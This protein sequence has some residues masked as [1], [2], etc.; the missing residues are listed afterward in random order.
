MSSFIIH[1]GKPL[2]GEVEVGGSK[3]AVLPMMA[4]AILA[5]APVELRGA[6]RVADVGGAGLGA[7]RTR[8][9]RRLERRRA[10]AG[11]DRP[12]ARSVPWRW[13]RRM[14]ASFCVLGPL[15]ARRGKAIVPLP[16]GCNLGDRPVDLHLRGLAALGAELKLEGGCVIARAK[17]L[18]GATVDLSGP[19]GPTVTGT[20]NVL[21]AAALA[22][23]VTRILA[24]AREPEIV[25]LG[26]LLGIM[27]AN[28]AGLGT[29][30]I[31]VRGVDSLGGGVHRVIPDRIETATLLLAA[32]ITGGQA[33]ATGAAP[34]HLQAVLSRL[35]DCGAEIEVAGDRVALR[36]RRPL[37]PVDIVAEPYPGVPTDLQ[38]QWTAFLSLA[39]GRSTI[40]DRVF[41]SRFFH[42]AELNRMGARIVVDKATA[43]VAGVER[44]GG[45]RVVASDLRAGAALVLAGLAAEGTTT[46]HRI[47]HLDRGYEGLDGKLRR[48]GAD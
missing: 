8:H 47:A 39:S 38:A 22:R 3:N 7:E 1:G 36:A 13:V 24:A 6:P 20:A 35:A 29:S 19:R 42:V 14:R 16:G 41:P 37:R 21:C 10:A 11:N 45:A 9:G 12:H 31:E 40:E 43:T 46:V 17:R 28:I 2:C 32:A 34:E 27:G 18:R 26:R 5:D 4:A 30:T 33:A 23:G 44:L 15:V 48:L 25:D